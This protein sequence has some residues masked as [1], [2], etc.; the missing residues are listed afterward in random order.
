M[1]AAGRSI[2]LLVSAGAS[3]GRGHLA[4]AISLAGALRELD[5]G[6]PIRLDLLRG[7]PTDQQRTRL[8]KLR[9]ATGGG[10]GEAETPAKATVVDLPNPN[11]AP[12][13][14][15]ES[16]VVFDDGD[17]FE[18]RA[19]IVI[20]PSLPAWRG[21]GNAATVLA[22]YAYAPID[23]AY[24]DAARAAQLPSGDGDAIALLVCF[25]GSDP[26]D[27]TGRLG[28]ALASDP[29]WRTTVVV[30]AGYRG[31]LVEGDVGD[32]SQVV[33]DPLDLPARMAAADLVVLG[34]GTMKFEAAFLGRPAVLLAAADDQLAVG[35]AFAASEAAAYL[36]D[37]RT[38]APADVAASIA[39]LIGDPA[40]RRAMGRRARE[41][42][43]GGGG[44][45]LASAILS[46]VSGA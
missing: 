6:V 9:V 42:V 27:V 41:V 13:D 43:D 36:G 16:L 44:A 5:D 29:R 4:R 26:D 19:A 3:E 31:A 34:A 7:A 28:A 24:L 17:R 32:R 11:D 15:P 45:R 38:I 23:Q 37:G 30:G 14:E 22:G 8:A 1:T 46:L 20:Q 18:G 10:G 25:G 33:R 21:L 12:G 2:R 39:A 40:K 35:P